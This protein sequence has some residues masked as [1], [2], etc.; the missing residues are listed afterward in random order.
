MLS[1]TTRL[2]LMTN[3]PSGLLLRQRGRTYGAC[4]RADAATPTPKR[5]K[6]YSIPAKGK[7]CTTLAATR[8]KANTAAQRIK[9]IKRISF[10]SAAKK[11][12]QSTTFDLEENVSSGDARGLPVA[13][14]DELQAIMKD[15]TRTF[16][17]ARLVLV[18]R[19]MARHGIDPETGLLIADTDTEDS[20]TE[21]STKA[22]VTT[23]P[24]EL[25]RVVGRLKAAA[26]NTT[27][28][29]GTDIVLRMVPF[30]QL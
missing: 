24:V 22:A 5:M 11:G 3:D 23:T 1:E 6:D 15:G 21:D 19:Q 18:Q 4:P 10:A 17:E 13:A 14:L 16:D 20:E 28:G 8:T 26:A 29:T 27:A 9:R 30:E 12:F 2:A 7:T 25:E